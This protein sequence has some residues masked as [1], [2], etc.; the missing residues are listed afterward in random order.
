VAATVVIDY[1]EARRIAAYLARTRGVQAQHTWPAFGRRP[2][3]LRACLRP[4]PDGPFVVVNG[5]GNFHHETYAIV[6]GL[7]RRARLSY[8]HV[9]AHPDKDTRF[10]WKL[11]CASFVGA[12]LE[13]PAVDEG[14]LLGLHTAT[15]QHDLPGLIL[16]SE[17]TYYRCEVFAKLR[18]YLARPDTVGEI[19]LRASGAHGAA[20]RRNPSVI[21]ARVERLP[22][23]PRRLARGLVVRWRDL[24]AFDPDSLRGEGVYLSVDLDV[25]R[26]G[27]VTDWRRTGDRGLAAPADNQGDLSVDELLDLLRAIGRRRRVLGAD[28]CGLTEGVDRLPES[29]REASLE[30][31]A[32]VYDALVELV[33]G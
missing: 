32:Q 28:L 2:E 4:V 33:G 8:V 9:D 1:P 18:Q 24:T 7:C 14:V 17:I 11:D 12:I 20:A 5:S 6:E 29:A 15:S 13:I 23:N 25:L 10:R 21:S 19:V 26:R 30:T 31:V 16:G 3:T 22:S 27:L